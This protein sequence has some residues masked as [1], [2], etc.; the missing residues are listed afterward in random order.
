M[1]AKHLAVALTALLLCACL[2]TGGLAEALT[3]AQLYQ[4]GIQYLSYMNA[5]DMETAITYFESAGTYGQA[6]RFTMYARALQEILTAET[7]ETMLDSAQVRLKRIDSP[8][9]EQELADNFLPSVQDLLT[10]MEARRLESAG[11]YQ[12]AIAKYAETEV[13][14]A[15]DRVVALELGAQ[16]QEYQKALALFNQG[17]YIDAAMIFRSLNWKDSA[18]MYEKCMANHAHEWTAA[19]CETPKTCVW[20]GVTEG[21]PLGHHWKAAACT[22]P[23]IC[24][25]CGLPEGS[26]LGHN[27]KA[28]TCTAP[29][30]CARCGATEGSALGH[31]WKA[32]TCTEPKTCTRCGAT[33]GRALDHDW[34]AATYTQPQTCRRCGK[35]I[36]S[37]LQTTPTPKPA[38][39]TPT[40]T[41]KTAQRVTLSVGQ[42]YTF[43]R[44]EQDNNQR[45]G[46]EGIQWYVLE[47]QGRR[48]LLLSVKILDAG[49]F[50]SRSN[51]WQNSSVR[52]WLNNAFVYDAFTAKERGCLS[53]RDGDQV[54]LLSVDECSQYV[55]GGKAKAYVTAYASA[56][57]AYTDGSTGYGWWWTRT[58]DRSDDYVSGVNSKGVVSNFHMEKDSG[59][60][61]P[62]IWVDLD[63]LSR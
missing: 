4:A 29:K 22:E 54:F 42:T 17:K 60:V 5:E 61:R 26:A 32:A 8:E 16:E 23:N 33:D 12:D 11:K 38:G 15:F 57:G 9:F 63:A 2:G 6:K 20:C 25:R 18:E 7:D 62:A 39:N 37:P 41:P 56:R 59:G 51:R 24:T 35:T 13:L 1:R 58:R 27:W 36:G 48:A 46:Q 3:K 28:A 47:V 43:G 50:S 34:Q 45:N 14:D 40:P 55:S 52:Q 19:T 30:T 49:S 10:Y 44:Y 21:S 53:S 31:N